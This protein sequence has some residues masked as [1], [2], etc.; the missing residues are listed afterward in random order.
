MSG[1]YILAHDLGTSGNKATLFDAAGRLV[2]S[3]FAPYETHYPHPNWAEQNPQAWWEAVCSA[4]RQLLSKAGVPPAEIAA[5]GFSGMMMGCLPVTA[6]GEPLRSCIIWADQRAQEEAAFIAARC[7]ADEVYLRCG[8]RTSAAYVAPKILWVRNHQPEI[9]ERAAK[10]LVPKDYLVYRLTGEFATDYSDASGTLLFDLTARRW[11]HP[12]LDALELSA[13]QL[14]TPYPSP[15]VVGRVTAQA[16]QATG[17]AVGTPVVIGGGDG[18]CA[19]VGAGVIEPGSAYCVIGT[20][21]WI[22]VSTLTPVPDP[23]QRTM[24]FHHVH[25]E[26][27]APMGVMQLAGGAREW[28]WKALADGDLDLDA[29]AAA[30]EPGA[31]GLLFLPYLMGERS[32]WWNP[33]ARGA[34]I[35]LAMPHTKAE[36]ARAVLEGV[37]FG[38][39]QILDSLREQ[40]AGIESLRLIGGGGRSRL[41]PQILADVFGLPIHVLELTGEATSWG[42]AVTAGVGVKLYDWSIAAERSRVVQVIE[43]DA[44]HRER[45]EQLLSLFTESYLALAPIYAKLAASRT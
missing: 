2:E 12:F 32:P 40:T 24:T 5:V 30:V 41:W 29:A 8:H 43:P 44:T 7:G 11:H 14:P 38:L 42:A 39:R 20:S 3:A 6:A 10:F 21:A 4:S 22:S 26:R 28:A 33:Q 18:S 31:G 23:Q 34:F 36:M 27:Y 9:Y 25:P 1:K 37:A 19:G 45:Y 15:T 35:G 17:L 16:A 13:G